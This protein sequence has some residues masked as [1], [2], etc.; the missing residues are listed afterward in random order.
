M[1]TT[2]FHLLTEHYTT[3]LLLSQVYTCFLKRKFRK[4]KISACNFHKTVVI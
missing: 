4:Q 3:S 2:L 1:K